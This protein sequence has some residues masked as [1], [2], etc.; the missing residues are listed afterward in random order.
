MDWDNSEN[1]LRREDFELLDSI[2]L[3]FA[4]VDTKQYHIIADKIAETID[5]LFD[6][7]YIGKRKHRIAINSLK[8]YV[9]EG[10]FDLK[11]AKTIVEEKLNRG[12]G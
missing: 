7:C 6:N 8:A 9:Q 4:D 10:C 5:M 12:H 3:I 2:D 11:K 1:K